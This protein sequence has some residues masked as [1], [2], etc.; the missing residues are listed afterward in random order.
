MVAVAEIV[1][2]DAAQPP[3][4]VALGK[5][6]REQLA[7]YKVPVRFRVVKVLPRTASGKLKR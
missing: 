6:C 7:S 5:H 2:R 3:T 4:G 1:P